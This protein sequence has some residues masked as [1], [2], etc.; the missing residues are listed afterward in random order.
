M[1][2]CHVE[3]AEKRVGE[4]HDFRQAGALDE[5]ITTCAAS[6]VHTAVV[7]QST[8]SETANE[9]CL[10]MAARA[11]FNAGVV[12][13]VRGQ[14]ADSGTLISRRCKDYGS[15]FLGAY[16]KLDGTLNRTWNSTPQ[17]HLC[18]ALMENR[19]SLEIEATPQELP[20]ISRI[21]DAYPTL[22]IIVGNAGNPEI[23]RGAFLPWAEFIRVLAAKPHVYGK[24]SGLTRR[25]QSPA[26]EP[27]ERQLAPFTNH[28]CHC[29]GVHKLVWGSDWPFASR[30]CSFDEWRQLSATLIQRNLGNTALRQIF[31]DNAGKIYPRLIR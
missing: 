15:V 28:L 1:I 12:T 30:T 29:F 22:P 25:L 13:R 23:D 9:Q 26:V 24:F 27:L 31:Q 20:L 8:D 3:F 19:L 21:A 17:N 2:D 10:A 6:A 5:Y 4:A 18:N 16:L 7:I 11:S 14:D